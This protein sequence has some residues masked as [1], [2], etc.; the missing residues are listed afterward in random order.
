MFAADELVRVLRSLEC[1][2]TD[3]RD[4]IDVLR[5]TV[6]RH[7]RSGA[8][9]EAR[10]ALD[11]LTALDMPAW[12]AL[13]GLID[14]VPTMHAALGATLTGATRPIEASAFEFISEHAQIQQVREF[15]QVLPGRLR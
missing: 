7:A 3:I 5:R 8:P 11:V 1:I 2:D 14:Q 15:M 10:S 4:G 13:A 9:W 12:A 6:I